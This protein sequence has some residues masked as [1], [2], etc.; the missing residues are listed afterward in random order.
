MHSACCS[1]FPDCAA[2]CQGTIICQMLQNGCELVHWLCC[3]FITQCNFN[4]W[5][6]YFYLNFKYC[7]AHHVFA[8]LWN[9]IIVSAS[10]YR[11][12]PVASSALK[13]NPRW[14]L[15]EM[16]TQWFL[17]RCVLNI[18]VEQH[19]CERHTASTLHPIPT[20]S[21]CALPPE[22]WLNRMWLGKLTSTYKHIL[23]VPGNI[24][25]CYI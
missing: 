25:N 5:S 24:F 1:F 21:S 8:S 23:L 16:E 7:I 17:L 15:L 3:C 10:R 11:H 12:S 4:R 14:N 18:H 13:H 22:V 2:L 6:V 20:S 9:G 19:P